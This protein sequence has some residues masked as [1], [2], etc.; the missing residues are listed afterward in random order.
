MT[1]MLRD[2][3]S[4]RMPA[5]TLLA[6][7]VL[8]NDLESLL[9]VALVAAGIPLLVGLLNVRVAEVVFLIGFGILLGPAVL[10]KVD[11]TDSITLLADMG[12]GFLFFFAGYELDR[13][14]LKGT[15]GKLAGV[16]WI[17]SIALAVVAV[18]VLYSVGL[19]Q[20]TLG[21]AIALTSTALGTLLP[22]IRDSGRLD[23]VFGRSFMAAGAIGEFGPIVA[24]SLLLGT[25]SSWASVLVLVAFFIIAVIIAFLP[26]KFRSNRLLA[27]IERGHSTSAQTA[28]RIVILLL[29]GLLA[30]ASAFGL[31][32]VLGAFAAGI[33][34]RLYVPHGSV[35]VVEHKLE[36]IAFGFFI[37]LFFVITGVKLDIQSIIDNPG[38]LIVFFLLLA[39]VRGLPQFFIYRKAIPQWR[40]RAELSLYIATALPIIVAVTTVQVDAGIML[41]ENA[42]ALVGA[43]ALSVLV[44]PLVASKLANKNVDSGAQS[45]DSVESNA[46]GNSSIE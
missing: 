7:A 30:V 27:I 16:G 14:V 5:A 12:L 1:R 9:W 40:A 8:T 32:L 13:A 44:F 34:V 23:S 37:P 22:V 4:R 25:R 11:L 31:D 3:Y 42:A 39:V 33:I 18:M 19:I 21:V 46:S 24:I 6:D 43:G 15:T 41:P 20:D 17:A 28:V 29:I 2:R 38:R 26:S 36:G 45:A 10:N 35:P